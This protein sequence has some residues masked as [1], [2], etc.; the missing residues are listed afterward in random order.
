MG[1]DGGN[2]LESVPFMIPAEGRVEITVGKYF[3]QPQDIAYLSFAS[4]SGF[5][6]GYTRF[7]QPGN[8]ASLALGSGSTSGWFTKMEK[9]G[10]TGIAFVN[11]DTVGAVVTL[12]A[13]DD[14][15]N[16]IAETHLS[17]SPGKKFVGMVDE[18]FKSDLSRATHCRYSSDRKLLGF[19]VSG[20]ADGQMLDGLHGL[21]DYVSAKR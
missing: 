12:T 7:Y 1:E 19:S 3:R 10:W 21:D 8:R 17:L 14:N 15:G 5:L 6:A 11:V 4:D 16:Q 20:S 18:L 13:W 2:P 9:D